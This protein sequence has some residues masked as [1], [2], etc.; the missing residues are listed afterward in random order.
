VSVWAPAGP[1]K[2]RLY[3]GGGAS[4][5]VANTGLLAVA[6]PAQAYANEAKAWHP[7]NPLFAFGVVAA[8]T[9]GLMAVSTSGG[10]SVRLGKTTATLTGGAG[11]GST[12]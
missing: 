10:A 11:I 2:F 9:F 5:A 8:L 1:E 6:T 3:D 12:K 4:E 7:S